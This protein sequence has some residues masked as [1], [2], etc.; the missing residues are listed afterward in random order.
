MEKKLFIFF[1]SYLFAGSQLFP[2]CAAGNAPRGVYDPFDFGA[3]GDGIALD[4]KS[5]QAAIEKC[6]EDG[7]GKVYLHNGVFVSGTLYMKSNVTLYIEG[8]ATLRG[9]DKTED[10]PVIPSKYPS[11]TG[12]MVTNKMLIYGED[13]RN[14]TICGRGTIDGRGDDWIEGPYGSPSFSLRPRILHFRACEN[15]RVRD[16]TLY[17]SAS[18]VQ[19]YQ[20]CRDILIDGITVDSRE[21]KNVL[22]PKIV[23][24][25]NTD[26]LDLVDCRQVRISNCCINSGDDAICLKSFSPDQACSDITIVNC[27]VS[28][29][30]SGIKIGTE[31]AG[32]F[33]DIVVQNC[34]V[35]DT[36][37]DALS[38]MTVDGAQIERIIFSDISIRNIRGAPVFIRLGTRNRPYRKG[39]AINEPFLKDVVFDNIQ[40]SGISS[41]FGCSVTGL[42][43]RLVENIWFRNINLEFEGGG[44]RENS[45]R[46]IPALDNEYP[47]GSMFGDL[48]SYGFFIRNAKNVVLED[49]RLRFAV[50]DYRPAMI[51]EYVDQL[52]IK[53][54]QAQ[55]TMRTAELIRMTD[56]RDVVISGS[57]PTSPVPAFLTIYGQKTR[58]VILKDNFLKNA[59]IALAAERESMKTVVTET[60]TIR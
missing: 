13:L 34:I 57:R 24:H 5:I 12:D 11:Y 59:T 48:P 49:V 23:R 43:S 9:S 26:G 51:C 7:G 22:G 36:G 18:W 10:F 21:N 25:R 56:V 6:H 1:L 14:I 2:V 4:T 58:N 38:L 45:Y 37:L 35:Y 3:K 54:F 15:I 16:V 32:A 53:D 40:G 30:A 28:S 44:K 55:A 60:G 20:S 29:T 39:A 19:S 8:G 41:R 27:V 50:D 17:N 46:K 47:K 42:E 33:R 52:V 31:S